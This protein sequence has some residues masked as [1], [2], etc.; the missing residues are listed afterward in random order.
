MGVF[1]LWSFFCSRY[2]AVLCGFPRISSCL[3]PCRTCIRRLLAFASSWCSF[4]FICCSSPPTPL[5][6][7]S[8]CTMFNLSF[9]ISFFFGGLLFKFH[10]FKIPANICLCPVLYIVCKI[11]GYSFQ[12]TGLACL[13]IANICLCPVLYIV[14]KIP[15]YSFQK[16]GLACVI[17]A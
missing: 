1:S 7:C 5:S 4:S 17:I 13:I 10:Q 15:G 2:P 16:T 3:A 12:K 8:L 9:H 11:P 6:I 14:C